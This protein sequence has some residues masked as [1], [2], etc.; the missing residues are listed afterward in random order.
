MKILNYSLFILLGAALVTGCQKDKLNP[1]IQTSISTGSAFATPDRIENQVNGLYTNLKA[2]AFMGGRYS[3]F[4]DI[5]GEN[6]INE[7]GNGVTGL[8]VWNFTVTGSDTY[9]NNIWNS[10]Y[11]TINQVNVFLSGMDAG[12]D[13]IVS[14]D[15]AAQYRGEAKFVRAVTYYGLLQLF[16]PPYT[17]SST[18]KALP[19]RLTPIIGPGN[20]NLARSTVAEVYQQILSDLNDAEAGVPASYS[21]AVTNTIHAHKNTVIAFK[22]RVYLSMGD[23]ANVIAEANKIVPATAPFTAKSG[24]ANALQA[25]IA[26]VYTNY[27]T[28]ESV[29]SLPFQGTVEIPGTQNQLAYYFTPSGIGVTGANGEYSLNRNGVVAD[30]AWTN[31]DARRGLLRAGTG[32]NSGK[33][34]LV[35]YSVG[36]PFTDWVPVLRWS[37]I[38]LNLAEAK[39]RSANSV[40]AQAVALLNAV[41]RRSDPSTNFEP[42]TATALIND[43]LQERNIEFLGEGLRSPDI[44]R[45]GMTFPAIGTARSTAVPPTSP[46]YVFPAPTSETQYNT[47]W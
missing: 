16:A 11:N 26:A 29:F 24:V 8:L 13:A 9:I 34:Y 45:L 40:D 7:Q 33:L 31:T 44:M 30:S 19:L 43:I 22:T 39:V 23:W 17:G 20:S 15:E 12:G 18:E 3:I 46:N 25:D 36:S 35:K 32:S 10:A 5:R 6:F 2:G 21:D 1:Q 42:A 28:T 38:L 41:R 14:P 4:N 27:T 47:L 37:E